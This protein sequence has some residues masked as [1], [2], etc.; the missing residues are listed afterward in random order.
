M[1]SRFRVTE[2]GSVI[3]LAHGLEWLYAGSIDLDWSSANRWACSCR[4][5]GGTWRLPYPHEIETLIGVGLDAGPLA[6]LCRGSAEI[7]SNERF[8]SADVATAVGISRYTE[9][10]IPPVTNAC[11]MRALAVRVDY[12]KPSSECCPVR[13]DVESDRQAAGIPAIP[14]LT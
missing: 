7:W 4:V 8:L 5:A 14:G 6:D 1:Q 2:Y 11:R 10:S 12:E 9:R 3:D 13:D